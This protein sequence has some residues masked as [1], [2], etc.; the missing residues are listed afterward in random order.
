MA[1]FKLVGYVSVHANEIREKHQIIQGR[2]EIHRESEQQFARLQSEKRCDAFTLFRTNDVIG[3]LNKGRFY[4]MLRAN[5][6]YRK[7]KSRQKL[8]FPTILAE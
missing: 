2:R 7:V 5:L 8:P 3:D 1:N 6:G 4:K